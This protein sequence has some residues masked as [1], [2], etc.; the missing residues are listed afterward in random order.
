ME[1]YIENANYLNIYDQKEPATIFIVDDNVSYLTIAKAQLSDN[2]HLSIHTFTTA[3]ACLDNLYLKPNFI[4][5]DYHL[6]N[7]HDSLDGAELIKK[8]KEH[9]PEIKTILI[10]G[11]E[12]INLLNAANKEVPANQILI[13]DD[14][15]HG[16][17]KQYIENQVNKNVWKSAL[18]FIFVAAL[19]IVFYMLVN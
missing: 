2:P 6:N 5:T 12:K 8:I 15:E 19:I 17:I 18:V 16:T 1:T 10:S 7:Q 4:I 13:K 9:N 3:K 14:K 11:D